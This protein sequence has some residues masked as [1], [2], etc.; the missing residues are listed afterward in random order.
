MNGPGAEAASPALP[1]FG[2]TA[3]G[4]MRVPRIRRERP[5]IRLSE[6]F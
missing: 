2:I 3:V 1:L 6:G 5:L 4:A